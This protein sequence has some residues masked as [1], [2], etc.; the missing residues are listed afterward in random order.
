MIDGVQEVYRLISEQ[1]RRWIHT[2][3][4]RPTEIRETGVSYVC[5][6]QRC[7]YRSSIKTLNRIYGLIRYR[8]HR[9]H[10]WGA[11]LPWFIQGLK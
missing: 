3:D 11:P 2:T 8:A 7:L 6:E 5:G 10:T 4:A 9:A 1:I